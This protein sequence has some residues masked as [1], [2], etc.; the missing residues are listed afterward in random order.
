MVQSRYFYWIRGIRGG[1]FE[2]YTVYKVTFLTDQDERIDIYMQKKEYDRLRL[3]EYGYLEYKRLWI[4]Y[5]FLSF[6]VTEI[7]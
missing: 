7:S 2:G 3:N 4:R 1:P 5:K 6:K